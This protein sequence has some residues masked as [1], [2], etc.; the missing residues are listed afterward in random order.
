MQ[1]PA[2]AQLRQWLLGEGG[3]QEALPNPPGHP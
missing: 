3:S 2:F 1:F